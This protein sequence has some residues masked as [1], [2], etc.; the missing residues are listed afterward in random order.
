MSKTKK[1]TPN[2][3]TEQTTAP[4][5]QTE[6]T[7]TATP[8]P[9]AKTKS[10]RLSEA[11]VRTKHPHVVAGTLRYETEGKHAGKQTA[12]A[13]LPCC[14]A[15]VR[16]ATSDLWQVRACPACAKEAG[17]ER[18]KAKRHAKAEA[19]RIAKATATLV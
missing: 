1:G 16:L 7:T 2:T 17:R 18:R 12:E 13:S 4:E 6:Q 9:E 5:T 3:Q 14:G 10:T 15:V 19:K 11:D 8:T